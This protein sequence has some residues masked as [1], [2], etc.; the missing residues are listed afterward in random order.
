MTLLFLTSLFYFL[1][2]AVLAA[3]ILLSVFSL[4]DWKE[5][6]SLW[7]THRPDFYMMLTTFIATLTFGIEEGVLAGVVLSIAMVLYKSS[8]PHIAVLGKL[9]NSNSYRNIKRF[10]SVKQPEDILILRFDDQ[11]YFGNAAFFQEEIQSL[12]HQS[13]I[14][15]KLLILDARS[16]HE[17]DSTGFHALEELYKHLHEKKI[18]FY[19]SGMIGPVRDKAIQ[20]GLIDTIG[21]KTQFLSNHQAVSHYQN[22]CQGVEKGWL[23]EAIQSNLDPDFD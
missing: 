12:V 23:P 18:L 13:T 1:P 17:M 21:A 5:A 20:N 7:R 9:P 4:F 19:I 3:I 15:I 16:I 8:R 2:R 22:L 6:K 11:L 10:D 14:P